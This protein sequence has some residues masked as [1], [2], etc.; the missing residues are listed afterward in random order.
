MTLT[1][2]EIA[3]PP[4]PRRRRW[5][6]LAAVA[7]LFVVVTFTWLTFSTAREVELARGIRL[8]MTEAEVRG[9]VGDISSFV[10]YR[11]KDASGVMLGA[12]RTRIDFY[13]MWIESRTK[14]KPLDDSADT[15]PVHIRFDANGC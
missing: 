4:L 6:P 11:G 14:W 12:V 8:G 15:W 1:V 13:A 9:V 3:V 7:A 2:T 5:M 10:T